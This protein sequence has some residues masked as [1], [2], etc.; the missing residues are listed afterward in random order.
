MRSHTYLLALL[1]LLALPL[2]AQQN[3]T[4][5]YFTIKVVDDQTGRGVPL[6]ELRTTH[7]VSY[8]TDSNGI[9]AF[10]EPGFMGRKVFFHISSHGY[11]YPKDGF[12]NRGTAL[13]PEAGQRA[14]VKLRRINI[15]ERLCRLTG[16][17]IYRDSLLV[18]EPAPL[19]KPHINGDVVGQDGVMATPYR[20]KIW[21]FWGDTNR[22]DYP[23]G[24]F[25]TSGAVSNTQINPEHGVDFEYFVDGAGFSRKMLPIDAPNPIWITG[26]AVVEKGEAMI[27]YYMRVKELGKNLEQG[28]AH[29][30]NVANVFRPIQQFP[31]TEPLPL[32]GHPFLATSGNQTYLFGTNEGCDPFPL[33]RVR[34]T[35][36]YLKNRERYESFTCLKAGQ[37]DF[38]IERD[39]KGQPI[40]GWKVN[41]PILTFEKEKELV[42][43]G[44][45]KAEE[46]IH[47]LRDVLTGK[48]I[49]PHA[50]SVFWNPYRHRWIMIVE[51]HG[52]EASFI[53]ELWFAEAD[54]PVGPW[55][56]ARQILTHNRYD[57]YNPTQHPFL[58]EA[59]GRRIYF[60]GTYVNTFSGNPLATPRYNYNQ[61]LYRLNLEDARLSL[62]AP[63]Y[64]LKSGKHQLHSK[65]TP[66]VPNQVEKIAFFALPSTIVGTETIPIYSTGNG[67]TTHP[68]T[69]AKPLFFALSVA[70]KSTPDTIPLR[71]S[72]GETIAK[73]WRNPQSLLV[74]DFEIHPTEAPK[75]LH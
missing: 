65:A 47:Q 25:G 59:D 68:P 44:V 43:K 32:V 27:T 72:K 6:V 20:G 75:N 30:D 21:W 1:L 12:G 57:F 16:A 63:V 3:R 10:D 56:Y 15:A 53:G 8:V 13:T 51:Q 61:I 4:T 19:R 5:P 64:Y 48:T 23:L 41:S 45:L 66:I 11:E 49:R 60:E 7:E 26:L 62:P 18:G 24:N 50:G 71:N 35:L 22:P 52:G 34:P 74:M 37:K 28:L 17:G 31:A 46:G 38:I 33:V 67:F 58:D 2:S 55:V 9:V 39:S 42:K 36:A 69:T 40:Y 70:A 54:T 73:V 29:Y 14:V